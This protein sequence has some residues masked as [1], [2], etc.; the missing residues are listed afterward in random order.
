MGR[1]ATRWLASM[2]SQFG[3]VDVD[4]E[5]FRALSGLTSTFEQWRYKPRPDKELDA[6]T[7]KVIVG[8][9]NNYARL[10]LKELKR[11]LPNC[12]WIFVWRDPLTLIRSL[13]IRRSVQ[14]TFYYD[15]MTWDEKI[16]FTTRQIFGDL[17]SMLAQAEFYSLNPTNFNMAEYITKDGFIRLARSCG[18]EI[19]DREV[20]MLPIE[21]KTKDFTIPP[22]EEWD[23]SIKDYIYDIVY[24]LPLV[25]KV[26]RRVGIRVY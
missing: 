23:E 4:F 7:V 24:N 1:C 16:R 9:V 10:Y 18:V 8:M 5:P 3:E 19:K 11:E 25:G 20:K 17:E 2:L 22:C 14:K 21:N 15:D 26:Y 12:K 6:S 13:V